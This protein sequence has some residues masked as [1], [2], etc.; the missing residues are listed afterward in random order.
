M[1]HACTAAAIWHADMQI[2]LVSTHLTEINHTKPRKQ[3]GALP[4]RL[5]FYPQRY[6]R[7]CRHYENGGMKMRA[8]L[9]VCCCA[10][11]HCVPG[12]C[13][14]CLGACGGTQCEDTAQ[15]PCARGRCSWAGRACDVRQMQQDLH[16]GRGGCKCEALCMG[17][18]HGWYGAGVA[19]VPDS[20]PALRA[21]CVRSFARIG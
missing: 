18:Q 2:V 12:C 21:R 3:S 7:T 6:N 15:V 4:A 9:C 5:L 1:W 11:L 14:N 13:Q 10:R 17:V 8:H 19:A 20:L 16:A